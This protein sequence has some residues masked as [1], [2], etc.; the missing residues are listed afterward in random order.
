MSQPMPE[1]P[2]LRQLRRQAKELRDSARAGGTA[3]LRRI[4]RS[5]APR[6]PAAV[7]LAIAQ[8][9]IAREHGFPSWPKLK[10]AVDA[11][12]G[13]RSPQVP[14]FLT[15]SVTGRTREAARLL[16][17]DSQIGYASVFAAA[18][19]AEAGLVGDFIATDP[20]LAVGL[21]DGRGWP[22]LLYACYS[23]WHRR[24]ARQRARARR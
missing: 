13:R 9:A 6:D 21:D 5:V 15:A 14:A 1:R 22:A 12:A 11:R 7:T 2:D 10:A 16:A 17:G 18:A 4:A 3:A 24:P 20:T 23:R 19:L 8:L